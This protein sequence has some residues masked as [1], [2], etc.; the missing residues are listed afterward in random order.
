MSHLTFAQ[1]SKIFFNS[2]IISFILP[3]TGLLYKAY[4]LKKFE[5]SYK[6]FVG[7]N[8]FL[9]WFYL[10]FFIAF[11]SFEILIFGNEVLKTIIFQYLYLEFVY[12]DLYFIYLSYIKNL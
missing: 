8:L 10:F 3:H 6:D 11:Y 7:I 9:A 12:Q 5:L 4:E 2:Q 1:Y